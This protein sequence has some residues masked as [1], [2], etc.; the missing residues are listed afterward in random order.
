MT[1]THASF[2]LVLL[3]T[4]NGCRQR[5][6]QSPDEGP[7]V[8]AADSSLTAVQ[9]GRW[10]A[11]NRALDSVSFAFQDSFRSEDPEIRRKAQADFPRAQ[12][13]ACLAAGLRGGYQEYRYVTESLPNP[14][15]KALRDS[16][17]V[18]LY[19]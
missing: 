16:L 17:G 5:P 10:V 4:A 3:L 13:Q 12:E 7:F 6:A 19:K 1:R 15:N 14:R 9:I 18:R 11:A 2:A 8:A